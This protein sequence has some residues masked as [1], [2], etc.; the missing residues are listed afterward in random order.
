[1]RAWRLRV[2]SNIRNYTDSNGPILPTDSIFTRTEK[3]YGFFLHSGYEWQKQYDRFQLNYGVDLHLLWQR[4]D[5]RGENFPST[6]GP[7]PIIYNNYSGYQQTWQSGLICFL[8]AKYFISPRWLINAEA[9]IS[10]LYER[11]KFIQ[12][13]YNTTGV[14]AGK[15]NTG[16]NNK[17]SSLTFD[18]RPIYVI[19]L[20]Y[21]F[22]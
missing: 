17:S 13:N 5:F 2:S 10:T 9:T 1:L 11:R 16:A 7:N 22:N 19:Q 12:E 15:K 21:L 4:F 3:D 8:G 20:S 6:Q 14:N 18:L